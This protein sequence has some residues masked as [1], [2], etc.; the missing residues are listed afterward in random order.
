MTQTNMILQY[1]ASGKSI[2]P[3]CA[4]KKYGCMRLGARI[5]DLRREG[6]TI[7]DIMEH[8]SKTGKRY[9]RYF[10]ASSAFMRKVR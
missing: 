10:L 3:L 6:H 8:N 4:L 5:Y 2:T 9:K 7:Y 1:M